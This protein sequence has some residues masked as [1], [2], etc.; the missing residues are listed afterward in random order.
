MIRLQGSTK[1]SMTSL[2]PAAD[3]PSEDEE[4]PDFSPAEV[5][6]AD[7]ISSHKRKR[8]ADG[9]LQQVRAAKQ[10]SEGVAAAWQELRGRGPRCTVDRGS[11]PGVMAT[12]SHTR[13]VPGEAHRQVCSG[14]LAAA[15]MSALP[16]DAQGCTQGWMTQLGLSQVKPPATDSSQQACLLAASSTVLGCIQCDQS[17]AVLSATGAAG[18]VQAGSSCACWSIG[19]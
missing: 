15:R 11:M 8:A 10:R 17:A 3:L 14:T 1:L 19:C 6:V 2:L 4:D 9:A 16:A 13:W 12:I 5:P 7:N 18:R